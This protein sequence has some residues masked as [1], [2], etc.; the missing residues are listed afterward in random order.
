MK[1]YLFLSLIIGLLLFIGCDRFE[2]AF[3]PKVSNLGLDEFAS[4]IEELFVGITQTNYL[5]ISSLYSN[6]YVNNNTPKSEMID[7]F[8]IF[9]LLDPNTTFAVDNIEI[10]QSLLINWHFTATNSAREVVADTTFTDFLIQENEGFVFYGNQNDKRKI[11]VELVTGQWCQNCPNFEDALHELRIK[12]SSRFSYVEYHQGDDMD[13][14]NAPIY[15]YPFTGTLPFG[16]VNGNARI[17]YNAESVEEAVAEVESAILPLLQEAPLVN[18]ENV[19]TTLSSTQLTGSI[20]ID[21][22]PSTPTTDLSLV[23]VLMENYN[24]EY[25]NY[26]GE[27]HHNIALRRITVDLSAMNLQSPVNFEIND[28]E[29]L[30]VWYMNNGGLPTDLTLVIWVQTLEPSYNESTCAIYNMIEVPL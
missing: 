11:V 13:P 20:Q 1:K 12:Y 23:A 18:L 21:L 10:S 29:S 9:F 6:E 2:H 26:H 24:D 19:Q 17:M 3:E 27:P 4:A 15:Y 22:D 25:L 8:G 14:E 30:P 16:V 5:E 28:L 7:Y